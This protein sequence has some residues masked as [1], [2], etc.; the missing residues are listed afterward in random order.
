VTA[1][2]VIPRRARI[3]GERNTRDIDPVSDTSSRDVAVREWLEICKRL[4]ATVP[5]HNHSTW[6]R[7]TQG[8]RLDGS[9]LTVEVPNETFK[10]QLAGYYHDAIVEASEGLSVRF[11]LTTETED[12]MRW[13]AGGR[14]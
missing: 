2:H 10:A 5:D 1:S 4:K 9:R 11:V 8:I 7:P 3:P 12:A 13:V 6:F 14:A